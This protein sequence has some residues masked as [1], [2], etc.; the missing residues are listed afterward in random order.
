MFV[1]KRS[2]KNP[3]LT[4]NPKEAWQAAA[5]FNPSAIRVGKKTSVVYRAISAAIPGRT[6]EHMSTI[7]IAE[8]VGG[9]N[10]SNIKQLISPEQEWE[11][12][13]CEDPRITRIDGMYYIFY[14]A[15]SVFPFEAKGIKVA[16]ALSKDLKKIQE[17]HLVTPFNAKAMALFPEKI[18]GKYYAILST[19]TDGSA[20]K[21]AI[22]SF[23][24]ITDMWNESKWQ[25]IY[26]HI[27]DFIIDP[28]RSDQDQ[29]EVGAVP[30]KTKYGWLLIYSHIQHFF[31]GGDKIFGIEALLL[32]LEDPRK[33]I[34]RTEGPIISPEE[35]YEQHGEVQDIVFPTG[36]VVDKGILTIYYGAADTVSCTA[37]V[38]IDDLIESIYA[39]TKDNTHFKRY[40]DNPILTPSSERKWESQGVLN[41]AAIDLQGTVRILYRAFSKNATSTIG[42]AESKNGLDISYRAN[43]P[44][45]VPREEFE[46]KKSGNSGCEDPR[47]VQVGSNIHMFYTAY[48][49]QNVPQVAATHIREKDFLARNWRWSRPILITPSGVDDKD[50]CIIPEKVKKVPGGTLAWLLLHRMGSDI[51]AD[52]L[53]S[54]D[55]EKDK[56]NKCIKVLSP[57]KGMWDSDKVG[58]SAPPIKTAYGWLLTYHGISHDHHT[59]RVGAALLSLTD[60]THVIARSTDPVLE[61]LEWYEKSGIVP[62][63]IFPCG[64]VERKGTVYLYYGAGDKVVGVATMKLK[65]L[66]EPLVRGSK[67]K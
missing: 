2:A 65:D 25:T 22:V 8:S 9:K 33:I 16:V 39:D 24:K 7:G 54:L 21:M 56:A 55:F 5:S 20:A 29:V 14:T 60:P 12:Y 11:K 53:A 63:V 41:P 40:H 26:S 42:Y 47:L 44:V 62:N 58:I 23:D 6:P 15:L 51:C 19:N 36:A 1:V 35:S 38:V 31:G 18:G 3:I 43:L 4:P 66:L 52:Y 32:D 27:D 17:R 28:R 67:L 57:R 13:G 61:P 37:S 45:Y 30:V 34:G 59:Y 49:G 48:N 64:M 10:F 46:L 50:T